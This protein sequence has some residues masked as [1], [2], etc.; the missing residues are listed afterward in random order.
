MKLPIPIWSVIVGGVILDIGH[1]MNQ[2]DFT[3]PI[4]GSGRKGTHSIMILIALIG[5]IDQPDANMWLGITIGASSHLR[6][7]NDT[8]L[9]PPN[10]PVSHDI[11]G[12]SFTLYMVGLIGLTINEDRECAPAH[13][14][15]NRNS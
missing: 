15:W 13:H 9:V 5:F 14:A 11:W 3:E 1:V 6:R 12:T 10:W 8:E 7:A 2:L 4:T